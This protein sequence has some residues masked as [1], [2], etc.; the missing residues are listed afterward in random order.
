MLTINEVTVCGFLGR[1]PDLRFTAQ[2]RTPFV[3]LTVATN[4]SRKGSD[5]QYEKLTD[6]HNVV[7]WG[8]QAE[9]ICEYMRKGSPIWVRGHL[10]TR[11]YQDKSGVDRWVTEIVCENF[12]FVQSAKERTSEEPARS[13]R[14]Q[15]QASSPYA[16]D[17]VPF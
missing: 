7:A 8:K 6:W 9:T 16:D 2:S 1:D 10:E 5:G 12:Q 11:K 4:R 17:D 13:D 15:N 14:R 3:N